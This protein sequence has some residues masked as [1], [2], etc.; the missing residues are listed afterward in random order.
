MTSVRVLALSL[1]AALA[2]AQLGGCATPSSSAGSSRTTGESVDD[3]ALAAKVKG[4]I[5]AQ[6]GL[7]PAASVKVNTNR[8]KVELSGFVDSPDQALRAAEAAKKVPGVTEVRNDV[9]VVLPPS[10]A[11]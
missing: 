10:G 7:T 2:A 5:A 6:A 9:A 4:A 3:A 1:A 8:G 11:S